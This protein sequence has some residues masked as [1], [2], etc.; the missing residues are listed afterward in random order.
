M[1][2]DVFI[3]Y[4]SKDKVAANAA[5]AVLEARN[6]R[7]WIAPR[8]VQ[9]GQPYGEAII[10][11]IHGCRVMVLV[12]SSH[13]NASGHI[14]K[15]V[16]RAVSCGVTIIPLRIEDVIPAKSLDYFIGSVHWLDAMTHPLEKHLADLGDTIDRIVAGRPAGQGAGT[17][18][19]ITAARSGTPVTANSLA[20][21][22]E[23]RVSLENIDVAPGKYKENAQ[24]P[25]VA[26]NAPQKTVVEAADAKPPAAQLAGAVLGSEIAG[27]SASRVGSTPG[28]TLGPRIG[29]TTGSTGQLTAAS[30]VG[31]V[32]DPK[33][34]ASRNGIIAAGVIIA[35]LAFG[36]GMAIWPKSKT[37]N[38]PAVGGSQTGSGG[39]SSSTVQ[40]AQKQTAQ[41]SGQPGNQGAAAQGQSAP[42]DSGV[43]AQRK[44]HNSS[45]HS[46][47]PGAG[48]RIFV[49]YRH[50]NAFPGMGSVYGGPGT[51]AGVIF[52]SGQLTVSPSGSI[53]YQCTASP[54]P[55]G[56][57][58]PISLPRGNIKSAN[59]TPDGA[60]RIATFS[61]GSHDFFGERS[62]LLRARD[63]ILSAAR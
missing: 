22:A 15:E 10:D 34:W 33:F 19:G 23:K 5:C 54:S 58:P 21:P 48:F 35:V 18:S 6:I 28:L 51:N 42:V 26:V 27:Q 46:S 7:C 30:I 41:E 17:A 1:A 16:E 36:L 53:R 38:E 3:S 32:R 29:S 8:D 61:Q 50:L 12:F 20:P 31:R 59:L 43:V 13:A 60:L 49:R 2:Y 11:A 57:E 52:S 37:G 62:A 4:A 45:S 47:V 56:C 39:A 55:R 14:P 63:T 44:T 9:P 40:D 25:A 24:A